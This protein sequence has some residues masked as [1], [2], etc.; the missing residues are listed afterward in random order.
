MQEITNKDDVRLFVRLFYTAARKDKLIGP[1]FNNKIKDE[2]WPVH[3]E[4]ISGFW[5][6]VLFGEPDYR[7]NPFAKHTSLPIDAE[8]FKRWLLLM[9]MTIETHFEGEKAAEVLER[10]SKMALMFQ[11][12]L[13]YIRENPQVKPII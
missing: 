9:N 5:N 10:A 7:G 6:T 8:H 12:K 1:V 11:H 13:K 4:R 3:L 2:D